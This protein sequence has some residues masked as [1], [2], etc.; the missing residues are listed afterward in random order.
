MHN[1]CPQIP[2]GVSG[3][4][5]EGGA[6]PDGDDFSMIETTPTSVHTQV[7]IIIIIIKYLLPLVKHN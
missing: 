2:V 3:E 4:E 7:I 1:C 5:G 6:Q